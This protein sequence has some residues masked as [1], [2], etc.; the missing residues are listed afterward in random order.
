[1]ELKKIV[2]L[3]KEGKKL[4]DILNITYKHIPLILQRQILKNVVSFT[5]VDDEETGFVKR[6]LIM[7]ELMTVL[8][9]VLEC[10]DLE[11]EGL[12]DEEGDI[13]IA[14]ALE[15]YDEII[16]HGIYDYVE[17]QVDTYMHNLIYEEIQQ[18][19]EIHNSTANVL[20]QTIKNISDKIPNQETIMSMMQSLPQQLSDVQNLSTF[21]QPNS[22]KSTKRSKKSDG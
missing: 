7:Q 20:S 17:S 3:L 1:M 10:T 9:L 14:V 12:T 18:T 15:A 2:E 22:K 5:I 19:L 8:S 13:D 16:K 11:I 21:T 4:E 6:D